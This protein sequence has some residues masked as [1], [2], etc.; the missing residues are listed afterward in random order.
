MSIKT[1]LQVN[2]DELDA[3]ITRV[4]AAKNTAASLPEAGGGEDVTAETNEYTSLNTEL[5]EV[6]N[7]LPE[8]GGGSSTPGYTVT[9]Q[10]NNPSFGM[11]AF[12][13]VTLIN[14]ELVSS[15]FSVSELPMQLSNVSGIFTL[16]DIMSS[17]AL[18]SAV[19]EPSD[20]LVIADAYG[21]SAVY[22]IAS[23]CTITFN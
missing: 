9:I 3:L 11:G 22:H 18:G 20:A 10:H 23:D 7:S 21:M 1:Q 16:T 4:N 15:E 6:I 13:F 8:A 19:C 17:S 5:E 2:N 14:N 12:R